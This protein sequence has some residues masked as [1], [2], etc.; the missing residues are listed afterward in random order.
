MNPVD[1]SQIPRFLVRLIPN[2][3]SLFT[4]ETPFGVP[5]ETSS[6]VFGPLSVRGGVPDHG[7]LLIPFRN[8]LCKIGGVPPERSQVV[9]SGAQEAYRL[10]G[11]VVRFMANRY[12]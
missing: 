4:S 5:E 12:E 10:A 6:R 8:W 7:F 3:S 1:L 2:A 9:P 11:N